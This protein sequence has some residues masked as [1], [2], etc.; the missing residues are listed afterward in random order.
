MT[1]IYIYEG[2]ATQAAGMTFIPKNKYIYVIKS[3]TFSEHY[4]QY[5][6]VC[7]T[8]KVFKV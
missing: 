2:K 6:C 5:F 4:S 1:H 8:V 7:G 3:F